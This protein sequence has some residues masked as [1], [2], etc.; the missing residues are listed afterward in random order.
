MQYSFKNY[1]LPVIF[2]NLKGYDSHLIIK[3]FNNKNFNISCI[4]TT[5]EKYLSFT[6]SGKIQFIDSMSFMDSSLEK[7]V[8][9]LPS[10]MFKHFD[11]HF[12]TDIE[13]K[14]LRQKGVYPYDL[15]DDISKLD[16]VDYHPRMLS[17]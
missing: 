2:H 13:Q 3:T 7:L 16:F 6:I 8:E 12:K 17:I 15:V 1:K 4:P 11:N 10:D 9:S 14:I 5:T